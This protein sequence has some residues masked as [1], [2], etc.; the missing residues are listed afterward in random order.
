MAFLVPGI[1]LQALILLC[2]AYALADGVLSIAAA[3]DRT[4]RTHWGAMLSRGVLGIVAAIVAVLMPGITAVALLYLIAAWAIVTGVLEIGAAGRLRRQ[5]TGEWLLAFG[6][7][8]SIVFGAV[9]LLF[10]AAGILAVV[11]LIA[12]YAI[13]FGILMCAL[14]ISLRAKG[15]PVDELGRRAA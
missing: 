9:L 14:G 11:W 5:I 6:G 4:D 15:R 1:T 7:I 12:A 8:L 13:V 2:A 3:I 10:P